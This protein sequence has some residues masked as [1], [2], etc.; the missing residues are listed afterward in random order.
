MQFDPG[1]WELWV[2]AGKEGCG[3]SGGFGADVV[4]WFEMTS[5]AAADFRLVEV[6][7]AC[8]QMRLGRWA[9]VYK[10][11]PFEDECVRPTKRAVLVPIEF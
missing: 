8:R 2:V 5:Y 10:L 1:R 6:G 3:L 11:A 7:W 4:S 9:N